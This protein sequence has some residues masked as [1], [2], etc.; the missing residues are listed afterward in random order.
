M[1]PTFLEN[2][3]T[4]S[5]SQVFL[6]LAI[7]KVIFFFILAQTYFYI[8]SSSYLSCFYVNIMFVSKGWE[9][10]QSKSWLQRNWHAYRE[11]I[12]H[13]DGCSSQL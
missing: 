3:Y 8:S 10:V 6:N 13:F 5:Q 9:I 7:K 12:R 11:G 4:S 2:L 1:P